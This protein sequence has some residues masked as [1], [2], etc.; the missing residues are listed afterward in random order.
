MQSFAPG[1]DN[2]DAESTWVSLLNST[3]I[4]SKVQ[5]YRELSNKV[6]E[7]INTSL[8][9]SLHKYKSTV[10]NQSKVFIYYSWQI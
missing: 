9:Y 8:L 7:F 10:T 5:I 4:N 3:V 2:T 6:N 1:L